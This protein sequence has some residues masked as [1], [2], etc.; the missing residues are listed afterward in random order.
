MTGMFSFDRVCD[1]VSELGYLL[2]S[3]TLETRAALSRSIVIF[4]STSF[5]RRH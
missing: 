1:P 2:A 5:D 3:T 4:W